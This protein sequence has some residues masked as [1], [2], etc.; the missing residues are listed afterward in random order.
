LPAFFVS[1]GSND[2]PVGPEIGL[3]PARFAN[4]GKKDTAATSQC[5]KGL[6]ALEIPADF[7]DTALNRRGVERETGRECKAFD[8]N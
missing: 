7:N 8:W 5:R 2:R 6:Q 3:N 4:S 1:A